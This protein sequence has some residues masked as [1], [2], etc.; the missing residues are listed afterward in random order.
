[1][2]S[3]V[4]FRADC[5]LAFHMVEP[6]N[7]LRF[8]AILVAAVAGLV[9]FAVFAFLGAALASLLAA[10]PLH[11]SSREGE[12]GYFAIAIGLLSGVLGFVIT[13]WLVLR[14]GGVR[15]VKVLVG[16]I[17]AFAVVIVS[18]ASVVGVWYSMQPHVLNLN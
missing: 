15:G 18:A 17:A 12:A 7:K 16:A 3:S 2:P 14:R 10:G 8:L 6:A 11:I 1:M 9:G 4:R 13:V 5:A